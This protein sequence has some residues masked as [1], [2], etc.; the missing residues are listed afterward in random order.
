MKK[1]RIKSIDGQGF[2]PA[3]WM[4]T[5]GQGHGGEIDIRTMG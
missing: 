4:L 3:F 5:N 2:W 1:A